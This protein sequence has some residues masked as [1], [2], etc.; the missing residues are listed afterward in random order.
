MFVF[1]LE[2]AIKVQVLGSIT[3]VKIFQRRTIL[4]YN[5]L[6]VFSTLALQWF[7]FIGFT[8][9][10][11]SNQQPS[12]SRA[13]FIALEVYTVWLCFLLKYDYWII[14]VLIITNDSDQSFLTGSNR[15]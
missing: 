4:Q 13:H 15:I 3:Q 10:F 11:L 14:Q 7:H 5:Y 8:V 6:S 12:I 1:S 9:T 2:N